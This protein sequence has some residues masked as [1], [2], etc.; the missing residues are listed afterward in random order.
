MSQKIAEKPQAVAQ[1]VQLKELKVFSDDRGYMFEGLRKDDALF[2]GTYGQTLVTVLY[3]G[4]VKAWHRHARQADYT[5]CAVGNVKY[6]VAY[7]RGQGDVQIETYYL[8]EGH[9]ALIKVPPGIWHGYTPIGG[10][11]AVLVHVMDT[12]YDPTDTQRKDW[13]AFGDVWS[14]KN[15]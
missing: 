4:V 15:G 3:P 5:L 2:D 13:L 7:E 11:R 6:C 12:T 1:L 8:G 9:Q 10:Q 14:V